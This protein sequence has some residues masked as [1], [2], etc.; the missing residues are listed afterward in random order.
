MKV[1]R[2]EPRRKHQEISGRD[3]EERG[4][5]LGGGK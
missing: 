4:T 3:G 2:S 5:V 1:R